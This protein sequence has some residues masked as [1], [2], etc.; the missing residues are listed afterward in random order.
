MPSAGP[1]AALG[2]AFTTEGRANLA[3]T[4]N[5]S[6]DIGQLE[7][8]MQALQT[9][10]KFLKTIAEDDHITWPFTEDGQCEELLEEVLSFPSELQANAKYANKEEDASPPNDM[11]ALRRYVEQLEQDKQLLARV[12][13][14]ANTANDE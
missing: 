4:D 12:L 9:Y 1:D 10:I 8:K 6:A 7:A 2:I 13:L 11:A 3:S 5:L 14:R